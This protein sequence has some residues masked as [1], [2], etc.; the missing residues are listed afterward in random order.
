MLGK[1]KKEQNSW[2]WSEDPAKGTAIIGGEIDFSGSPRVREALHGFIKRT[3]GDVALDLGE[4]EY[5]DSSGLAVLIEARRVLQ[6]QGRSIRIVAI[7]DQV[8]KIFQLTQVGEL[9]GL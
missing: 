3:Q 6:E 9:F 7:T 4:L 1:K 5:L 2:T 8:S